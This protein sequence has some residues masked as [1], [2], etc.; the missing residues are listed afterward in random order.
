MAPKDIAQER[1]G[2]TSDTH[3]GPR[4]REISLSSAI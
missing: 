3:G 1:A 4:P 2:P